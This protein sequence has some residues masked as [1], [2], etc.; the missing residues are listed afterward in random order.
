M[1]TDGG[2]CTPPATLIQSSYCVGLTQSALQGCAAS[3]NKVWSSEHGRCVLTN[4]WVF[5]DH[6]VCCLALGMCIDD[7][8]RDKFCDV[9]LSTFYSCDPAC[10]Y[11]WA[12]TKDKYYKSHDTSQELADRSEIIAHTND[13]GTVLHKRKGECLRTT[14]QEEEESPYCEQV[15]SNSG[16]S[17][18]CGLSWSAGQHICQKGDLVDEL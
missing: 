12:L 11:G 18:A 6:W 17:I 10:G 7:T 8:R 15:H 3:C 16:C 14:K 13:G 5:A 4:G 2:R 9:L 1:S